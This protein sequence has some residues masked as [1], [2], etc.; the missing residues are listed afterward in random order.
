MSIRTVG[1]VVI[2]CN[3]LALSTAQNP[4]QIDVG[5]GLTVKTL[6][7]NWTDQESRWFY[8]VPQGSRLM[9][10]AWFL[11]L[12]QAQS[13]VLF[14]DS[15]NIRR[16]G[17]IPRLADDQNPDG[18]PIGFVRDASYE[19]G[20]AGLG[21][22]CAA[23][24][25]G[26]INF[27]GTAF[28]IDGGPTMGDFEL[29][30]R[31]LTAALSATAGDEAKFAR[32]ADAVL[33]AD[34]G[35]DD[36]LSLRFV[37]RTVAADRE[38]YNLRN[39]PADET[40]R[41]GPGRVDAFGAIFNEVAV[42]FLDLPENVSAASAPVSYPCLWDAPQHSRV[43][44]NGAA[45]NRRS[46]LGRILF[47]TTEVGAL[48][49]NAGEVLGVFGHIDV[50]QTELLLPRRYRSTV[51][52]SNLIEIEAALKSLWSPPWPE[53]EFGVL[54][55]AKRSRGQVIYND[56]CI[57]CHSIIDR[58]APDRQPDERMADVQTD[59]TLLVNFGRMANTGRLR[60]RQVTLLSRE[61]FGAQ[62][63]VG[64]I[65]KHVVER[66]ILAPQ[67]SADALQEM[68]AVRLNDQLEAIDALN[69][70]FRM[71]AVIAAGE[72]QF[73]GQFDALIRTGNDL[74][75]S[76]GR[77]HLI[78][79]GR[80]YLT[81]GVGD[82]V[83]D[84]RSSQAVAA[85]SARLKDL[86]SSDLSESVAAPDQPPAATFSNSTMAI[87]YKARPLNGIWATAPYLHNGSVPTLMELLRPAA[88]RVTRFHV[89]GR[90]FDINRIGFI[91]DE[92][93]PL[94]DTS[95]PGNSNTGHEFATD[96]SEAEQL[97]L[98]EYLKS[99]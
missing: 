47:G 41:F 7:Q 83:L 89:G 99:L 96:L 29:L 38:H 87:G 22:T 39:L 43:Q 24:H 97:D 98:L 51:H 46:P 27:N 81:D 66:A 64:V 32:F 63:P 40:N 93:K 2:W 71:T 90:Q 84:L 53:A 21:L 86:I 19:D 65:L 1:F 70:G 76:G 78:E 4:R 85:A 58:T 9:P 52:S 18:L 60:G 17:Y 62:A 74:N 54:N 20:T 11:H 57:G 3:C 31:E 44:W 91:D 23:C 61:R 34:A 5:E 73:V 10:Y 28:L 49:R 72:S 94:F 37:I 15:Q 12:E 48:G 36:R 68:A 67:L 26:Q 13:S 33:P 95:L 75:V 79:K 14:R 42:T 16:L 82:D 88:Q 59:Q 80:N 25:T 92:S 8:H 6:P 69:P 50:S 56:R 35:N 30:M 45:E 77:F 55:E